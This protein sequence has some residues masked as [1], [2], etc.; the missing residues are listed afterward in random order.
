[1]YITIVIEQS[2]IIYLFFKSTIYYI[3]HEG[4]L[5]QLLCNYIQTE[6]YNMTMKK[7]KK[8]DK[9]KKIKRKAGTC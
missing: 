2:T 7:T 5:Q 6:S 8:K 4:S 9:E 1:M 3:G